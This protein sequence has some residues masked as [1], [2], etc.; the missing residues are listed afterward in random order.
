M[1]KHNLILLLGSIIIIVLSILWKIDFI[2]EPDVVIGTS[3]LTAISYTFVILYD[4]N[5]SEIQESYNKKRKNNINH[6]ENE[7]SA[8]SINLNNTDL[9]SNK[10]IIIIGGN[11]IKKN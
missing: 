5:K 8:N 11:Q 10:D 4:K 7:T 6:F 1:K 9:K 3:I 2:S